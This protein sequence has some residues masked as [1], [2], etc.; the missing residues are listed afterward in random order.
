MLIYKYISFS[1]EKTLIFKK[2]SFLYARTT[3]IIVIDD[4]Q[5][6]IVYYLKMVHYY[7]VF[8]R[9]LIYNCLYIYV[10]RVQPTFVIWVSIVL[11]FLLL[12][13]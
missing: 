10:Y 7:Y 13:Q 8:F 3:D 6:I 12:W 11:L 5:Y 2:N 1:R 4:L 9:E